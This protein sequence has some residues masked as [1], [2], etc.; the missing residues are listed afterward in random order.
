[1]SARVLVC[2]FGGVLTTPLEGSFRAFSDARGVPLEALAAAMGA[3]ALRDGANPLHELECGRVTEREFLRGLGDELSAQ[4][5]RPV[6]MD[7]F[8]EEY[9]GHLAVNE[10]LLERLRAWHAGGLRMIM[11]TNNVREWE[12]RWRPMLAVD[13]LFKDVVDS[14]F[15]GVRKPDRRIYEIVLE[16]LGDVAPGDCVFLD[17]FANNCEAARE[18]GMRAVH[19]VDNEQAIGELERELATD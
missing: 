14:G 12:P 5:G 4:L 3:L 16:R 6:A 2:D 15:V 8:A 11:C 9:F 7:G 17:D 18:I 10:P 19:F 13:E 1:M